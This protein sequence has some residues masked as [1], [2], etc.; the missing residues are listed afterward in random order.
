MDK[1]LD[2][3]HLKK[4]IKISIKLFEPLKNYFLSPY[5]VIPLLSQVLGLNTPLLGTGSSPYSIFSI[6]I[7]LRGK[8][9][10]LKEVFE[11]PFSQKRIIVDEIYDAIAPFLLGEENNYIHFLVTTRYK[12]Y[13]KSKIKERLEIIK[14]FLSIFPRNNVG[15]FAHIAHSGYEEDLNRE[16][17]FIRN[18][19][20]KEAWF[21]DS[22]PIVNEL[23]LRN[24]RF[25][26]KG[27][28]ILV[29]NS[30]AQLLRDKELRKRK[31]FQAV[32]LANGLGARIVGMGG[33]NSFF[34]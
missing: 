17:A 29:A 14:E 32:K 22:Y 20:Q 4:I 26:I 16:N 18:L 34:C 5:S 19:S 13:N 33:G 30:T 1:A 2:F 8:K 9:S 7:D 12:G 27:W 15:D 23:V 11:I 6:A 3:T 31:I 21:R 24:K 10:L 25:E 28:I